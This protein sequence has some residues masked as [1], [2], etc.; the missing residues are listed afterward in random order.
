MCVYVRGQR[1]VKI[2]L[3]AVRAQQGGRA[4]KRSA[5]TLIVAWPLLQTRR[6]LTTVS[7]SSFSSSSFENES[8][9]MQ[10]LIAMIR[11]QIQRTVFDQNTIA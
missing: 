5:V 7:S 8:C 2:D 10:R 3:A 1:D 9:E 11:E 4:S 6:T